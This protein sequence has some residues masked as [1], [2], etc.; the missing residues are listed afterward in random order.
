[1][2]MMGD[3]FNAQRIHWV[4]LLCVV[5]INLAMVGHGISTLTPPPGNSL[6]MK[7]ITRGGNYVYE[8][9]S[10]EW[11]V[12]ARADLV[13]MSDPKIVLGNY[14]FAYNKSNPRF[15]GSWVLT[16]S[17]ADVAESGA[18]TSAVA[19]KEI[20][21]QPA[22]YSASIRQIL[23]EATFHKN[24][25]IVYQVSYI[26]RLHSKGGLLP[27]NTH[28][29]ENSRIVIPFEAEFWFYSQ[30]SEPPPVPKPIAMPSSRMV[31]GFYCQ[32][33]IVYSFDGSQWQ[34]KYTRGNLYDVPGGIAV[35]SYYS[36]DKPDKYGG[37]FCLQTKNPNGWLLVGS[38]GPSVQM[39]SDSLPWSLFN[40]TSSSGNVS[41]LGPFSCYQMVGTRGGMPPKP[42]NSTKKG[43]LWRGVFSNQFWLY[44]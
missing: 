43:D 36:I 30:D 22:A 34:R 6:K 29:S 17:D 37:N 31:E 35:G 41:L 20:A 5:L 13:N 33:F 14:S 32:G 28:C 4:A 38:I 19:G 23:A 24:Y 1:M 44:K 16:N 15:A 42:S 11:I 10:R 27:K 7:T 21:S 18:A 2:A 12:S 3:L 25:G 26:Q 9:H 39:A 8:C 40:V